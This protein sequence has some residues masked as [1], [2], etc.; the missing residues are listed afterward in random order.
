MSGTAYAVAYWPNTRSNVPV[1]NKHTKSRK[2][3]HPLSNQIYLYIHLECRLKQHVELAGLH[4]LLD[5]SVGQALDVTVEPCWNETP[6]RV[7]QQHGYLFLRGV[8]FAVIPWNTGS[9]CEG[10]VPEVQEPLVDRHLGTLGAKVFEGVAC[11]VDDGN[12]LALVADS[13]AL[14][15]EEGPVRQGTFELD[16]VEVVECGEEEGEPADVQGHGG[17]ELYAHAN[18]AAVNVCL[19]FRNPGL[20]AHRSDVLYVRGKCGVTDGEE[21]RLVGSQAVPVGHELEC[22]CCL[23]HVGGFACSQTEANKKKDQIFAS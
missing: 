1:F 7:V 18:F 11:G 8:A 15:A 14:V 12:P 3:F 6:V 9:V 22:G 19:L 21:H 20:P 5:V 23:L 4:L 17:T 13:D 2:G 10:S 16:D